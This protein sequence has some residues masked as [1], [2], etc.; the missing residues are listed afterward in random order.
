MSPSPETKNPPSLDF[1]QAWE[2]AAAPESTPVQIE[3]RYG[4]FINGEFKK[5]NARK[6]METINPATEEVL[7]E[8]PV[9]NAKDVDAAV[10]AAKAAFP[11]WRKLKASERAKYLF[12]IARRIQERARELAVLETLDGGKPIKESRDVDIPEAAKFF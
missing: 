10:A 2:Y 1:G 12:R 7:S 5:P 11:K 4:L 3:E 6:L 9:A 8:V